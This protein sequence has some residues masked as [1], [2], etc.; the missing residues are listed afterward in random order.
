[1]KHCLP[2][3]LFVLFLGSHCAAKEGVTVVTD[4][5]YRSGGLLT[6]YEK[7]RCKLDV[8]LPATKKSFATLVWFHGGG[9]T[10]GRKDNEETVKIARGLAAAG[11]ALVV[12]NYRLSPKVTFPAYLKD[13]A[14]AVAW[15]KAHI[16][17]HGGD[18]KRIFVGGHSAGGYIA[19]MLGMDVRYLKR[20][21]VEVGDIAG[22]IPVS[23]QTMTHYTVRAERGEA[24]LSITADEAAPVHFAGKDAPPFLVL[25]ADRDMAAR[26]EE[27]LYFVALMK[28]AGH[29]GIT[30]KMIADRTHGSVA[31]K[32]AERGDP[33]RVAVLEFMGVIGK[34]GAR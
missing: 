2:A 27:N 19:L 10:G 34:K 24:K 9:L 6:A 31:H 22:F 30:G 8:Y 4:I 26:A 32:M 29:R 17:E 14:A 28:G 11:I 18:V 12:P 20:A 23:G 33:G 25:Y 21:G 13:A 3:L 16:A 7:E 5:A 1:M 15:A